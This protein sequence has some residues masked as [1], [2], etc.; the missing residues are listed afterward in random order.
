VV[1]P[2]AKAQRYTEAIEQ[3]RQGTVS[4]SRQLPPHRTATR[5]SGSPPGGGKA[6][7]P[8]RGKAAPLILQTAFAR[9]DFSLRRPCHP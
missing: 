6:A 7:D 3:I 9:N 8:G 1:S 5:Q 4:G 2:I